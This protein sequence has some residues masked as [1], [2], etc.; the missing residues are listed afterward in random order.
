LAEEPHPS[1]D[2]LGRRRQKELL[3]H[4]LQSPQ[5]QATQS[6]LILEFREQGFDLLS[7][8]LCLRK[9]WRVRQHPCALPGG[10]VHVDGKKAKRSA[11]ALGFERTRTA[12]FASPDVGIGAVPL[13][14]TT[15]VE[16]LPRRTAIAVAFGLIGEPLRNVERTVLSVDTVASSHIRSDATIRQPVQELP[17][18]VGRIG[19]YRF[20]FSFLPLRE[21]SEH[22][23]RRHG[24][25]T[26]P[27]CRR[28]YTDDHATVVVDQIVIVV[29]QP[30]RRAALGGVSRIGIGGRYL[31]LLMHRFFDGILLL[32][33][34]QV[35][36]RGLVHLRRFR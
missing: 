11:G 13:V 26:H 7:F 15:V 19:R 5:T 21:T 2:V 35:L 22:V 14:A 34:D 29:P 25:L 27:C 8:P 23:L 32:Q 30:S 20:W 24:F 33:F 17:V 9:L 3:P 28:L 1:L 4:K 31:V 6:D 12:T 10:F 16:L 18:P 36:A